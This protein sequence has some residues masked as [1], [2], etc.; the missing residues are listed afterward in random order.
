MDKINIQTKILII[1]V[2][3]GISSYIIQQFIR[4]QEESGFSLPILK[5]SET[6]QNSL[7]K[8]K[9][10]DSY[11]T[12]LIWDTAF[13]IVYGVTFYTMLIILTDAKWVEYT[14][15]I[16][17]ILDFLENYLAYNIITQY[18]KNK[19]IKNTSLYSILSTIKWGFAGWNMGNIGYRTIFKVGKY[20][21]K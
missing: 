21:V 2:G 12:L 4:L 19:E 11:K 14:V 6:F 9:N 16:H 20:L 5:T 17:V 1:V 18:Q 13:A 10:L 7:E 8:A 3:L 15:I